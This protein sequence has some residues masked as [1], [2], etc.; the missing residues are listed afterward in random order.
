[1]MGKKN[2]RSSG[3]TTTPVAGQAASISKKGLISDTTCTGL[4]RTTWQGTY[5]LLEAEQPKV[6]VRTAS[7]YVLRKSDAMLKDLADSF[8]HRIAARE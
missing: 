8:L 6:T 4:A 5:N 2:K 3:S 1:M 7:V